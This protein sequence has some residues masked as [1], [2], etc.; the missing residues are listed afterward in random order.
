MSDDRDLPGP[1]K[2]GTLEHAVWWARRMGQDL[3]RARARWQEIERRRAGAA[4]GRAG[5][6]EASVD[7]M[8]E[9]MQTPEFAEAAEKVLEGPMRAPVPDHLRLS[10]ARRTRAAEWAR[11]DD[12]A[13]DRVAA[14]ILDGMSRSEAERA[15]AR[16]RAEA[17]A[18]PD[19]TVR[20]YGE[21]TADRME[22]LEADRRLEP[23][24]GR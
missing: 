13:R 1:P 20:R 15:I 18:S 2:P 16:I 21:D 4:G 11:L 9:R 8:F 3:E 6:W 23:D 14:V 5:D 24:D 7:A 19:D 22:R 12:G 10:E 17:A